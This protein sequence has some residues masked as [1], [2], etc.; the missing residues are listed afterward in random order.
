MKFSRTAIIIVSFFLIIIGGF[1]ISHTTPSMSIRAH[2][3]INGYPIGAF[4]GTIQV[5]KGQ[6]NMDKDVLH[7]GNSMI[8][9]MVGYHIYD[10]VTGDV[11][12]NYK[13]KK[14]GFLYFVEDYGEG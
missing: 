9:T 5:N 3:F 10:R 13:V 12:S 7:R 2:I 1:I 14:I 8:Y 6:Y 4:K 11:I